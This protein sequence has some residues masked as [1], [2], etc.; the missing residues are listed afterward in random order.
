MP[1][2]AVALAI[3]VE[4]D[5]RQR[6]CPTRLDQHA[7]DRGHVDQIAIGL[8]ERDLLIRRGI[9]DLIEDDLH[10][11]QVLRCPRARGD[12]ETNP[13]HDDSAHGRVFNTPAS[14]Q[15]P[16]MECGGAATALGWERRVGEIGILPYPSHP[17][18]AAAPPH[19][20]LTPAPR[21]PLGGG[22]TA[23]PSWDGRRAADGQPSATRSGTSPDLRDRASGDRHCTRR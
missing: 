4:R 6:R 1:E 14:R 21:W 7:R 22:C 8:D 19:S 18:A 20:K 5:G 12:Q 3:D 15:S 23:G 11:G 9:A 16:N 17:K 13:D 2:V 10:G